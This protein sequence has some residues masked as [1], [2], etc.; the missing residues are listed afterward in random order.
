M[1]VKETNEKN[2]QT[3]N[4]RLRKIQKLALLTLVVEQFRALQHELTNLSR[5]RALISYNL[6]FV[7][8]EQ[9]NAK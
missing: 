6:Q 2:K 3:K 9:V 8:G 1:G 4:K 5:S 7:E